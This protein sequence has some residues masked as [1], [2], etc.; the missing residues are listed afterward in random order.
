[1]SNKFL[2]VYAANRLPREIPRFP[3]GLIVNSATDTSTG[4]HWLAIY[5]DHNGRGEFFDS[6]GREPQFYQPRFFLD[7]LERSPGGWSYSYRHLQRLTSTVCGHYC[8]YYLVHRARGFSLK[9]ILSHFTNDRKRND[10]LVAAFVNRHFQ[11]GSPT[12]HCS[13][14][15]QFCRS[16]NLYHY[17]LC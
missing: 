8:I 10:D 14:K 9:R 15:E 17:N 4:V 11:Y 2:G 1:M 5:F 3:C 6:Y 7:L 12:P 16:Y 13:T